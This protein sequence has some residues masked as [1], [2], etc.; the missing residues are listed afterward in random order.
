[1]A[2]SLQD[3]RRICLVCHVVVLL[4]ISKSLI[5]LFLWLTIILRMKIILHLQ[6]LLP[7]LKKELMLSLLM[8]LR[9]KIICVID[10]WILRLIA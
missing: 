5:I 3:S 8:L 10:L 2:T 6:L 4:T 9:V 7:L 1:M